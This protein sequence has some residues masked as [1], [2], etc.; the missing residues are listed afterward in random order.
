[1]GAT[2]D[3]ASRS[4]ATVP[5]A[6]SPGRSWRQPLLVDLPCVER[7]LD[8]G[9]EVL[10]ARRLLLRR[11][12]A[13]LAERE[14]ELEPA[15]GDLEERLREQVRVLR[16]LGELPVECGAGRELD[17]QAVVRQRGRVSLAEHRSSRDRA[18]LERREHG[19]LPRLLQ[20]RELE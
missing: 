8:E 10:L 6:E 18:A 5:G 19:S 16:L 7:L 14:L 4:F 1:M 3:D 15:A 13:V 20:L 9:D 2:E 12:D 17:R 11:L